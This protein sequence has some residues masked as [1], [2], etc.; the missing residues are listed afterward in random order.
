M[1]QAML[2]FGDDPSYRRRPAVLPP[3]TPL[4]S[5]AIWN[6]QG[7]SHEYFIKYSQT[8]TNVRTSTIMG[9]LSSKLFAQSQFYFNKHLVL[10]DSFDPKYLS[11]NIS[12]ISTT[13][14]VVK[15]KS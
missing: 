9:V 5:L 1:P 6:S 10:K 8:N 15:S 13:P 12:V 4:H 14:I 3:D 11:E 2:D 7:Q